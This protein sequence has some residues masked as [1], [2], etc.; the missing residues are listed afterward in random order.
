VLSVFLSIETPFL[1][2]MEKAFLSNGKDAKD[3]AV[4]LK[5]IKN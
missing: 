1:R 5:L 4:L 3:A 2:L